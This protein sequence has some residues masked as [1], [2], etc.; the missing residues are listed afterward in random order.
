MVVA[1]SSPK[2][3][4]PSAKACMGRMKLAVAMM[5]IT[6]S[7]TVSSVRDTTRVSRN[8]RR[9]YRAYIK[10]TANTMPARASK[11]KVL[12]GRPTCS[13]LPASIT[14]PPVMMTWMPGEWVPCSLTTWV[15][16]TAV[17]PMMATNTRQGMTI[18]QFSP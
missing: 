9:L 5:Q 16:S 17:A 2:P 14:M 15:S 13:R 11:G 7:T 10:S 6:A 8:I 18:C 4:V 1:S 12:P 3:K